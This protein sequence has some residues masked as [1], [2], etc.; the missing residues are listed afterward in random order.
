MAE[1]VLH[2]PAT[3]VNSPGEVLMKAWT[4]GCLVTATLFAAA[5]ERDPDPTPLA[6]PVQQQ[7]EITAATQRAPLQ[8]LLQLGIGGEVTATPHGD[9]VEIHVSVIGS[10]PETT[11][12]VRIQAGNCDQPGAEVA[13]LEAIRSGQLGNGTG[14]SVVEHPPGRLL[15]GN[16]VVTVYAGGGTPPRDRPIA[17]AP[18]PV[19]Q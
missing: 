1:W 9:R 5:C 14:T 19:Q 12:P 7:P 3:I 13:I 11:H 4:C 10:V 15:D 16:H 18:L 6:Q 17:C 2:P 8:D